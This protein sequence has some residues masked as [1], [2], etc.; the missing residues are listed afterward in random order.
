M[1]PFPLMKVSGAPFQTGFQHGRACGDLI[2]RYRAILRRLCSDDP[3]LDPPTLEVQ[4]PDDEEL[5]RRAPCFLPWIEAFVPEKVEEIRG[6]AVAAEVPFGL[7]LLAN[8]RAEVFG[9]DQADSRRT[10]LTLGRNATASGEILVGQ[11]QDQDPELRDLVVV[12]RVVPEWGLQLLMATFGCLIDYG[13]IN[14]AGIGSMA[15]ALANSVWRLGPPHYPIKRALLEQTSL[16]RCLRAFDGD[17]F[18]QALA[19]LWK[20][21]TPT[22]QGIT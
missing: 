11:N 7:A 2:Q 20:V 12:L 19:K 4:N 15:N 1:T 5:A 21:H 22:F 9:L 16:V 6:V 8:I 3:R 18:L 10:V 13:R 14:S 17:G